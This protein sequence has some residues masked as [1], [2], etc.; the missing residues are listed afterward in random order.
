MNSEPVPISIQFAEPFPRAKPRR[1]PRGQPPQQPRRIPHQP[2]GR[3][4]GAAIRPL[5]ATAAGVLRAD[6]RRVAGATGFAHRVQLRTW[7][8]QAE[9]VREQE[10]REEGRGGGRGWWSVQWRQ[11]QT[12]MQP[13]RD[14]KRTISPHHHHHFTTT[15]S[16][17]ESV[18]FFQFFISRLLPKISL[19]S[20]NIC[21]PLKS[22]LSPTFVTCSWKKSH[23][24]QSISD[25]FSHRIKIYQHTYTFHY[26]RLTATW[27]LVYH[28]S[29]LSTYIILKSLFVT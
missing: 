29:S 14:Y 4:R 20:R 5:L 11:K 16:P 6:E 22:F 9:G 24:T 1:Q 25:F 2:G 15:K 28:M 13:V 12:K 7:P 21:T 23:H 17:P 8:G 26:T 3:P 19:E 10:V 27:I 18:F